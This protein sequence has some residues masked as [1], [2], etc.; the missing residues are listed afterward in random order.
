MNNDHYSHVQTHVISQ[1]SRNTNTFCFS[2]PANIFHNV[3]HCALPQSTTIVNHSVSFRRV[4]THKN[5]TFL[6]PFSEAMNS[7]ICYIQTNEPEKKKRKKHWRVTLKIISEG[8]IHSADMSDNTHTHA[9]NSVI[10][11][12]VWQNTNKI[13]ALPCIFFTSIT[14]LWSLHLT[15]HHFQYKAASVLTPRPKEEWGK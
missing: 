2:F 3:M 6:S 5:C 12:Y 13:G 11:L 14:S 15:R 9:Q 7:G 8:H 1:R 4:L 10:L